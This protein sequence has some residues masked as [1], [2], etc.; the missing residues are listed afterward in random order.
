MVEFNKK[1]ILIIIVII[2]VVVGIAGAAAFSQG[3]ADSKKKK[4]EPERV[5]AHAPPTS[6]WIA[7]P[8]S[9]EGGAQDA[10][11]SV[12]TAGL[13]LLAVQVNITIVD[14]DGNH[15]T[16]D[17]GSDP[18][19]VTVEIGDDVFEIVTEKS[20]GQG[21][22]VKEYGANDAGSFNDSISVHIVGTE[23]GGGL[24]PTG[25]GGIVPI[26]FLV[27]I[28]QGCGYTVEIQYTYN[29]YNATK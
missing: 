9:A 6:G 22:A 8:D 26:P 7:S 21:M 13:E 18:D 2:I 3:P 5:T 24:H 28:D 20:S 23:F 25:P 11:V 1:T 14:D 4:A 29:D 17:E 19:T 27:Y 15:Q 12:D 16:T 10:T